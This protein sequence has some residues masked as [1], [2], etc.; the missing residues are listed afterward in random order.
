MARIDHIGRVYELLKAGKSG[1]EICQ[2]LKMPPSV[3]NRV[4]VS[5]R[6]VSYDRLERSTAYMIQK[7]L[8]IKHA[9]PSFDRLTAL[10]S[11]EGETGRKACTNLLEQLNIIFPPKPQMRSS[12]WD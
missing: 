3:L 2:Q 7:T 10:A 1:P 8:A 5:K 11:G 9:I 6:L 4:L 12:F